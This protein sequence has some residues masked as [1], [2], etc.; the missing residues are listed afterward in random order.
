[1]KNIVTAFLVAA[2]LGLSASAQAQSVSSANMNGEASVTAAPAPAPKARGPWVSPAQSAAPMFTPTEEL[3]YFDEF[4]EQTFLWPMPTDIQLRGEGL[5]DTIVGYGV[6]F[7]SAIPGAG[8]RRFL[9]SLKIVYRAIT[10]DPGQRL[11]FVVRRQQLNQNGI[12]FYQ[13]GSMIDTVSLG[14][15]DIVVN[16]DIEDNTLYETTIYFPRR[17]AVPKDFLIFAHMWEATL[18]PSTP[19]ITSTDIRFLSDGVLGEQRSLE[20]EIDRSYKFSRN[21]EFAD[22][23]SIA[24]RTY[25]SYMAGSYINTETQEIIYP[26]FYWT[27]YV[28]GVADVAE[29]DATSFSLRQN[30]PNPFNPST[31][32]NYSLKETMPVSIKVFNA[33]GVELASLVNETQAA[34]PY[35]VTFDASNLPSGNY[36]YTMTAGGETITK[37]MTLSK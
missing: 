24:A 31:E 7:T 14:I 11:L 28:S 9:D 32:I 26:N 17:K 19:E 21:L 23:D 16:D 6:R 33:M 27:A 25:Q 36:I 18:M 30:Y 12:P 13:W 37:A 20:P 10:F 29:E 5:I 1:M 8:S 15:D 22:P 3:F 34:G 4:T 35:S 2:T